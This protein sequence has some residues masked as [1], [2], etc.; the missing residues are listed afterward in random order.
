[1]KDSCLNNLLEGHKR[2][3][4]NYHAAHK[5]TYET[6]AH[7]GQKPRALVICC[8]DSRVSPSIVFDCKPGDIFT[9]RNVANI[10]P[11]YQKDAS[12]HG[13]SAALEFATV[14]LGVS[15]IIIMGHSRCGGIQALMESADDF[16]STKNDSFIG[17]WLNIAHSAK[18]CTLAKHKEAPFEQL[19]VKCEKESIK[20]SIENLHTFPWVESRVKAGD[21]HI[22]GMHFDVLN[23]NISLVES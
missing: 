21:L 16:E 20:H 7:E 1:M 18:E 6:L 5:E 11:P 13:T 14:N 12:Y 10:V 3:K 2:F 9:I 17:A 23:G 22:H 8:S 15:D 4:D 19:C